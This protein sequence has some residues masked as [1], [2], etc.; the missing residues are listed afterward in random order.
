MKKIF[1]IGLSLLL[2]IS[3]AGLSVSKHICGDN[4]HDIA[5]LQPASNCH[6]EADME[7]NGCCEDETEHF[8]VDDDFQQESS[9]EINY[10]ADLLLFVTHF[11]EINYN[12]QKNYL[13]SYANYESPPDSGTDILIR[14]QSFLL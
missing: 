5:I 3:T 11:L 7:M 14:I 4:V 9:L 6:G 13:I 12:T 2:L 8:K 10:S 1:H